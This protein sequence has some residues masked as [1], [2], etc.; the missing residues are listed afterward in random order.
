MS[1]TQG[2]SRQRAW[3]TTAEVCEWLGIS[4]ETLR[5]LRLRGFCN[6]VNTSAAGVAP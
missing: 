2:A 5:Q 6:P 3:I 1:S 4:R